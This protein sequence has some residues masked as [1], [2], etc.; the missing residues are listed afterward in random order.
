MK[1]SNAIK[2]NIYKAR[3]KQAS[4]KLFIQNPAEF[5]TSAGFYRKACWFC[6]YENLFLHFP[7]FLH[8][9]FKGV[10]FLF[11]FERGL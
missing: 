8:S 3:F 9:I 2:K 6:S 5:S 10:G 7:N 1:E 11:F 4:A